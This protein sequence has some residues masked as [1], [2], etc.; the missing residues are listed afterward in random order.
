MDTMRKAK[1]SSLGKPPP[2]FFSYVLI[3]M[4][5]KRRSVTSRW[6]SGLRGSESSLDFPSPS[7]AISEGGGSPFLKENREIER[8]LSDC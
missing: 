7:S 6:Y 8:R 3:E 1:Y 4:F 5:R 2:V